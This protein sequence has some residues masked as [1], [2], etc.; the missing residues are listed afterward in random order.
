MPQLI[1]NKTATRIE[2]AVLAYE[3][4]LGKA[5][6]R[7]PRDRKPRHRPPIAFIL[8]DDLPS[9]GTADGA[10]L[11]FRTDTSLQEIKLI[12]GRPAGGTFTLKFAGEETSPIEWKAT[13]AELQASLE[14][15]DGIGVGHVTVGIGWSIDEETENVNNPGVWLVNFTGD[16]FADVEVPLLEV[17]ENNLAAP[18]GQ[19]PLVVLI[20]AQNIPWDTGAVE[21]IHSI[22]P[23]GSPTPQRAG[24]QGLAVWMPGKGYVVANIEC[25]E[26]PAEVVY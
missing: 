2:R 10:V 26:L 3:R 16:K 13:A 7:T 12:G 17:G 5:P 19:G 4:G 25:R 8:L 23:V 18:A 20:E 9:R 6:R 14:A 1:A 22:T 15:L 21:P 11:T 24:A